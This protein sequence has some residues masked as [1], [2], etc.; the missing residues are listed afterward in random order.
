MGTGHWALGTGHWALEVDSP[1]LA[2]LLQGQERS[3]A[4]QVGGRAGTG[5]KA[6]AGAGEEQGKGIDRE[7]QSMTVHG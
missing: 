6:E 4:G 1:A 2:L 5:A 3:R 7:G